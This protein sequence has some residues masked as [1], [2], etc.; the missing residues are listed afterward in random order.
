MSFIVMPNT[1]ESVVTQTHV[2]TNTVESTYSHHGYSHIPHI[3][4]Y[5]KK[6]FGF[7]S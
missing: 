1:N 2:I 6:I 4:T 7:N 3:I 5:L